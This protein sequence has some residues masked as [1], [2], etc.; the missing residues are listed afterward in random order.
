MDSDYES[1]L[2][3]SKYNEETSEDIKDIKFPHSEIFIPPSQRTD[4]PLTGVINP[5]LEDIDPRYQNL[6]GFKCF[7]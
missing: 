3:V 7:I 1:N 5:E 4:A 2:I 6:A